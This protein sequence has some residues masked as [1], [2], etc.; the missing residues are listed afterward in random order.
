MNKDATTAIC[1][2]GILVH[3]S[4][5]LSSN[6]LSP[7][8]LL[9]KLLRKGFKYVNPSLSFSRLAGADFSDPL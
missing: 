8:E 5:F 4:S 9:K 1:C 6:D 7:P 3:I 2:C